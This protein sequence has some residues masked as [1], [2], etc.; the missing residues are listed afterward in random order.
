MKDE[1]FRTRKEQIEQDFLRRLVRDLKAAGCPLNAKGRA[2]VKE[3]LKGAAM[4]GA[5]EERSRTLRLLSHD[6]QTARAIV[7]ESV[8]AVLGYE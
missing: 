6:Q 5:A 2:L 8:L 4:V 3:E 7:V 1:T